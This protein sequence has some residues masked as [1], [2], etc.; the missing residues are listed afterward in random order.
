MLAGFQIWSGHFGE[1]QNLRTCKMSVVMS[2]VT[3]IMAEHAT[4]C[5]S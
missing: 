2:G 5:R 4:L 1:E 3:G